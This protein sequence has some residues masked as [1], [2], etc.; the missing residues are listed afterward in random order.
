MPIWHTGVTDTLNS[1][2]L[3]TGLTIAPTSVA[4]DWED[5]MRRLIIAT[6][7]ILAASAVFATARQDTKPAMPM[8]PGM[9]GNAGQMRS[10][11]QNSPMTKT[12]D[13]TELRRVVRQR[14]EMMKNMRAWMATGTQ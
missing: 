3:F 7:L 8:M 13:V 14:V 10:M 5:F 11:M 6:I 4:E 1:I 12:G 2:G 9:M